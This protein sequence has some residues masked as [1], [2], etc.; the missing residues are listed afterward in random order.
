MVA[1]AI[2]EIL[3]IFDCKGENW[4]EQNLRA[5]LAQHLKYI[6]QVH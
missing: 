3:M 6:Y 1:L 5:L 4:L 2:D